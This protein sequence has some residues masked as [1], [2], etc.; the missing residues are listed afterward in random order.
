MRDKE[1]QRH[2]HREKQAPYRG[3][4]AGLN[5]GTLESGHGPKADAKPLSHPGIPCVLLF[6]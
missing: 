3:P 1:R 4:D 2:R 5:P 6:M